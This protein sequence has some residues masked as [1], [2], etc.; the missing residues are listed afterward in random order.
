MKKTPSKVAHNRPPMFFFST[1]KN[2]PVCPGSWKP[3]QFPLFDTNLWST[4]I[5]NLLPGYRALPEC[6]LRCLNDRTGDDRTKTGHN[7]FLF[8]AGNGGNH[9]FHHHQHH[10]VHHQYPSKNTSEFS[11]QGPSSTHVLHFHS[12]HETSSSRIHQIRKS[13]K[14]NCC[15]PDHFVNAMYWFSIVKRNIFWEK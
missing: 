7:L 4:P 6:F 12:D 5:L 2:G 14:L 15:N 10:Q 1:A 8:I 9:R 13:K 11:S 3:I